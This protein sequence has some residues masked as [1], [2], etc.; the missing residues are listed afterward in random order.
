VILA[1]H[2]N[3]S[4]NQLDQGIAYRREPVPDSANALPLWRAAAQATVAI[5]RSE[6]ACDA[7]SASCSATDEVPAPSPDE[8]KRRSDAIDKNRKALELIDAGIERGRLQF[9]EIPDP[10]TFGV[11][12]DLLSPWRDLARVRAWRVDQALADGDVRQAVHDVIALVR[13]G[14]LFSNADGVV[15]HYLCGV[16]FRGIATSSLLSMTSQRLPRHALEPL[17]EAINASLASPDGLEQS[18]IVDFHKTLLPLIDRIPHEAGIEDLI[19]I[20]LA[21]HYA[22]QSKGLSD[23]PVPD[24]EER[25]VWRRERLLQILQG[26]PRPFDKAETIALIQ[27]RLGEAIDELASPWVPGLIEFGT[28]VRQWQRQWHGRRLCRA[29]RCWP[30]Q[31]TPVCGVEGLG[32]SDQARQWLA[33]MAQPLD[34]WFSI[35]R[36][37]SDREIPRVRHRL[38]AVS[39]PVGLLLA[40]HHAPFLTARSSRLQHRLCLEVCQAVLAIRIFET[41][42]GRLPAALA[43]VVDAGIVG[44]MPRDPYSRGALHYSAH[45]RLVWSVGQDG[46]NRRGRFQHSPWCFPGFRVRWTVPVL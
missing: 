32:E 28:R 30:F 26:H 1:N 17:L 42:R 13:F 12:L 24:V 9:P 3:R 35:F 6:E 4:T 21:S 27:Q 41:L 45:K 14:D 15:V 37:I 25:L 7:E 39:N 40:E 38:R 43:E 20:L 46:R 11:A 19:D 31:L 16:A 34:R 29:T 18:M 33:K 5:E 8:L 10:E 36:P 23:E 44:A 22:T 2:S